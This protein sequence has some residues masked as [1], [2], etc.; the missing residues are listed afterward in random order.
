[1]QLPQKL[2]FSEMVTWQEAFSP[3]RV[4]YPDGC[5]AIAGKRLTVGCIFH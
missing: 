2:D 3:F 4:L 5:I 1:M